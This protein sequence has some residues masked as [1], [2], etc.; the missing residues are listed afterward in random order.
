MVMEGLRQASVQEIAEIT[1]RSASSLYPHLG[2]LVEAGFLIVS[3][4]PRGGRTRT[5]YACGPMMQVQPVDP[6]TGAG[7]LRAAELAGMMLHNVAARARRMGLMFEG[8]PVWTTPGAQ[9]AFLFDLTWL[10]EAGLKAFGRLVDQMQRLCR[11]GQATRRGTRSQVALC[12]FR[13]VTLREM[14]EHRIVRR[15]A[16]QA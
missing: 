16:R 12:M 7:T 4:S 8:A 2:P 11:K 5:T 1:G 15:S 9:R 6:G 14:R 3:R 13:D 10:D